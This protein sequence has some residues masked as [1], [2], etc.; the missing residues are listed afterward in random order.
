MLTE[1]EYNQMMK[2]AAAL[3]N[4]G[5]DKLSLEELRELRQKADACEEYEK[6]HF[7][8]EK[9][10]PESLERDKEYYRNQKPSGKIIR[11]P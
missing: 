7:P 1:S 3:M 9:P 5:S 6:L 11:T 4:K 2:D 8:L 10:D